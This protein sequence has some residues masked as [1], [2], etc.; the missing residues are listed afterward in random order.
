MVHEH[1]TD[2]GAYWDIVFLAQKLNHQLSE[3]YNIIGI[4]KL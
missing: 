1:V 4:S 3:S 2:T